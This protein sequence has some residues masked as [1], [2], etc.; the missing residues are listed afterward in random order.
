MVASTGL[1]TTA[2]AATAFKPGAAAPATT[3]GLET[4]GAAAD[5]AAATAAAAALELLPPARALCGL[6]GVEGFAYMPKDS[7]KLDLFPAQ[8]EG[9]ICGSD[10]GIA[11][12]IDGAL[13]PLGSSTRGVHCV[14]RG[15][16]HP[17]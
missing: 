13:R 1:A 16:D 14:A 15:C 3:E 17:G 4:A 10:L 11:G 5:A 7:G 12:G 2:S 6:P 8:P 9:C